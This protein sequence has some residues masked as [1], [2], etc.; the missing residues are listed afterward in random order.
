MKQKIR[1]F[2]AVPLVSLT[3]LSSVYAMDVPDKLEM[4]GYVTGNTDNGFNGSV[5]GRKDGSRFVFSGQD[6]VKGWGSDDDGWCAVAFKDSDNNVWRPEQKSGEGE[7]NQDAKSTTEFPVPMYTDSSWG[8]GSWHVNLPWGYSTEITV[9]F[10]GERPQL[11]FK[12]KTVPDEL[13]VIG[14]VKV[15]GI[16]CEWGGKNLQGE[17]RG[18][19]FFFENVDFESWSQSLPTFAF[20]MKSQ[21]KG[22]MLYGSGTESDERIWTETASDHHGLK[23][24]KEWNGRGWQM[25]NGIYDITVTFP[26]DGSDPYFTFVLKDN[27]YFIGD[28]NNWFSDEFTNPVYEEVGAG[29]GKYSKDGEDTFRYDPVNGSYN[30]KSGNLNLSRWL[31]DQWKFEFIGSLENVEGMQGIEG[32][33]WYSFDNFPDGLLTGQFKILAGDGTDWSK[34]YSH[35]VSVKDDDNGAVGRHPEWGKTGYLGY[36]WQPVTNKN[37]CNGEIYTHLKKS[38]GQNLFLESNGVD[39]AKVY[40]TPDGGGKLVIKGTPVDFYIFYGLSKEEGV[41]EQKNGEDW[42]RSIITGDRP[43]CNNYFLPG[44]WYGAVVDDVTPEA[45]KGFVDGS[46]NSYADGQRICLPSFLLTDN[47]GNLVPKGTEVIDDNGVLKEGYTMGRQ[48]HMHLPTRKSSDGKIDLGGRDLVR[49]DL[50]QSPDNVKG[51]LLQVVNP[52]YSRSGEKSNQQIIDDIV[53]N[54]K[55]PDGRSIEDYD[56]M[57]IQKIPNSFENPA[58]RAYTL[59]FL[60]SRNSYTDGALYTIRPEHLYIFDSNPVHIHVN[61]AQLADKWDVDVAYRIYSYD[62]KSNIIVA[63]PEPESENSKIIFG[64]GDPVTWT[65]NDEEGS[66]ARDYGWVTL[67]SKGNCVSDGWHNGFTCE[68][69]HDT[70]LTQSGEGFE[71]TYKKTE[72]GKRQQINNKYGKAFVQFRVTR[73][74]K[75]AAVARAA[76][77]TVVDY[78]PLGLDAQTMDN[79]FRLHMKDK[80]F[81]LRSDDPVITGIEDITIEEVEPEEVAPVY[82]NL[83][84][85]RVSEPRNGL[86]IEVRGS[87]SRKVYCE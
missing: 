53:T 6:L 1:S 76:G 17:K 10:S 23:L 44:V 58:G 24:C 54:K 21:G 46:G 2:L 69:M 57:W 55:L 61:Y 50:T 3:C 68:Q 74:P 63:N 71:W 25:E 87:K 70:D 28:I 11:I 86:F 7:T 13:Y 37:V 31:K 66:D 40:F 30:L 38:V 8:S 59:S 48:N 36:Y 56:E 60:K 65:K 52:E 82:Y 15:D 83:Q 39:G 64:I 84:G 85:V 43:N 27:Y 79:R 47:E 20:S 4:I 29:A 41:G 16:N 12:K 9:D 81:V 62:E 45:Y 34:A 33:N 67:D 73:T 49:I 22:V 75:S 26:E 72:D 14:N 80:Y 78:M 42:I 35:S 77:Q 19:T 32:S 18:N 5:E 51:Q